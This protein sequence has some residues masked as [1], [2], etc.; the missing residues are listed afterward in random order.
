MRPLQ[1]VKGRQDPRRV[2][3][4]VSG[5][6]ILH[7]GWM[8]NPALDGDR[9]PFCRRAAW[10]FLIEKARWEDGSFNCLGQTMQLKRGQLVGA[11]RHLA[12]AWGWEIGK[13][14]RFLKRLIADSMIDVSCDTGINVITLRN[15]D[16]YQL[17]NRSDDTPA[18]RQRYADDTNKNEL[19]LV[20]TLKPAVSGFEQEPDHLAATATVRPPERLEPRED[21]NGQGSLLPTASVITLPTV[22]GHFAQF[23][24]AYP[25][26]VA[27]PAALRA[28]KHALSV[29]SPGEILAG[30]GR[31][32]W[33]DNPQY[34]PH[35]ATWLN[36]HR[37]S[38]EQEAPAD[39]PVRNRRSLDSGDTPA[40]GSKGGAPGPD[41]PWGVE[42]WS[43]TIAGVQATGSETE[44]QWGN[45]A[46]HGVVIDHL[47]RSALEAAGFPTSWRGDLS[48]VLD[49]AQSGVY[50]DD[51]SEVIRTRV[52]SAKSPIVSLRYF[53]MA[54]RPRRSA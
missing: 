2:E 23:W 14:Q 43:R 48:I 18:I 8:D 53:D 25:R 52:A 20:S 7:R 16:V 17:Q 37:W 30:V 12:K 49:W 4:D 26:K 41:D 38:D 19:K 36:N 24:K 50:A 29:S 22:A 44:R 13:V 15:Y 39:A 5:F 45:W 40:R 27:K 11:Y 35:P 32:N 9:E 28:Y 10:A 34:N 33:S 1:F 46:I 21:D 3:S 42:A 47:A 54:V 51:L 6:Y 31:F